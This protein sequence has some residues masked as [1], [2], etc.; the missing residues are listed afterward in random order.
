MGKLRT[1]FLLWLS[2]WMLGCGSVDQPQG[3]QSGP[4]DTASRVTASAVVNNVTVSVQSGW[5]S[6]GLQSQQVTAL[7]APPALAGFAVF[8]NG[9]YQT[10]AL[11]VPE[12]NAGTGGRR[13]LWVFASSP[14]SFTYS[15]VDDGRGNFVDV[16]NG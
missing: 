15:G 11:T 10:R 2:C 9:A 14:A 6:V 13:G 1:F 16:V 3:A 8:E 5:N 7:S 12:L 4:T